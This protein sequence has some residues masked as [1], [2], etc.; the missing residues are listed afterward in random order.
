M[1]VVEGTVL[2]RDQLRSRWLAFIV[3]VLTDFIKNRKE[4]TQ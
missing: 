4:K 1:A 3:G 2:K